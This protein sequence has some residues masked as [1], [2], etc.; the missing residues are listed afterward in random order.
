MRKGLGVF[1]TFVCLF[2]TALAQEPGKYEKDL[3]KTVGALE[4]RPAEAVT[5][6]LKSWIGERFVFLPKPAK[7]SFSPVYGHF[8]AGEDLYRHPE[9]EDYV[10]KMVEAVRVRRL[11]DRWEVEFEVLDSRAKLVATTWSGGISG[12]APV[13]DISAAREKWLG[14]TLWYRKERMSSYPETKGKTDRI[15]VKPGTPVKVVDIVPGSNHNAPVRFILK[16][17]AGKTG[18]VDLVWSQTNVYPSAWRYCDKFSS[19]FYSQD[20]GKTVGVLASGS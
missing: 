7:E 3:D 19:V 20:P 11:H 14:K 8:Q 12:I 16:T 2:T 9:Y 13:R 5:C 6:P 10:G 15:R 1:M 4:E 18:F 17:S